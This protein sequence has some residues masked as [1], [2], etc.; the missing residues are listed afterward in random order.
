VANGLKAGLGKGLSSLIPNKSGLVGG[1]SI[2]NI[3]IN[4]I[5]PNPDQPRKH[6]NEDKL[7]EL[8]NSIKTY[9]ILQPVVV[10][11]IHD[12]RYELVAGERRWR[13]SK[14]AQAQTLPVIVKDFSNE[15]ALGVSLVE[16]IQRENLNVIE[17][18]SA[19]KKLI[20]N[21]NLTQE[22]IAEKVG[23][24]R[25][26]IANTLRLLNLPD[27]I[28]DSIIK[29]T[30]T[31][32]HARTLAAVNDPKEQQLLW[33]QMRKGNLSVREAE[34]LT[35]ASKNKSNKKQKDFVLSDLAD[36]LSRHLSTK[37]KIQGSRNKGMLN[38]HY[39]SQE[40][41]ERIISDI[42]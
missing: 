34:K 40:D 6:F 1:R 3:D 33:E 22:E 10:K 28:Q 21:L 38:I 9:G 23:K 15:Q 30:I 2:L 18:A 7:M 13:A 41:L 17:E 24:S 32:G 35:N 42:T 25:S 11:K 37:V 12:S 26:F 27:N 5:F 36:T 31:A 20:T 29:G 14:L 19:Y 8:A 16:N 4:L 39:F